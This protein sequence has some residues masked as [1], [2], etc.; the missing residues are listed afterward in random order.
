[1]VLPPS[2]VNDLCE[3]SYDARAYLRGQTFAAPE[4]T[5]INC[6]QLGESQFPKAPTIFE[7]GSEKS[8]SARPQIIPVSSDRMVYIQGELPS[9]EQCPLLA[10]LSSPS[11]SQFPDAIYFAQTPG[12]IRTF[13]PVC[14]QQLQVE[15]LSTDRN[16]APSNQKVE[17]DSH[18]LVPSD[19]ERALFL[20]GCSTAALWNFL[21][22]CLIESNH[23]GNVCSWTNLWEMR[24][25]N[26]NL[27]ASQW[28]VYNPDNSKGE[29]PSSEQ[30]PLLAQLSSPSYSQFPDAIYFAQTPGAIR[31]FAPVCQQQ[32][33]VE[34]LSTD[35]NIAPSNQK[36]END[37][38]LLVPS[39]NERA[40]FLKGCSTAALWNFL[41]DCLIESNH[42]GNVCSWTN[43]WE[44]RIT[45][46]NLFASQWN[47][48]NP[49]NSKKE[50]RYLSVSRALKRF[51]KMKWCGLVLL[52]SSPCRRNTFRFLPEHNSPM[53][54]LPKECPSASA[55][56]DQPR[57]STLL[58]NNYYMLIEIGGKKR[59]RGKKICEERTLEE[60]MGIFRSKKQRME[61]VHSIATS[62]ISC[63]NADSPTTVSSDDHKT[64][65]ATGIK[66]ATETNVNHSIRCQTLTL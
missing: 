5:L 56:S 21:I 53:L 3:S 52:K 24:I 20:K 44:M 58:A 19:N 10:Q 49:D 63:C 9:S 13:A 61:Y 31:T 64:G 36:V 66:N 23:Y 50:V 46:T 47:V 6:C 18:L 1:M 62:Q 54:P 38:H 42:Y 28:N 8:V 32:L 29:L 51:E 39:D 57:R 26:T 40:L 45:N 11:Y 35:R 34:E 55:I 33:Q 30:C 22:D 43:L 7:S 60:K 25:T 59:V 37:S 15:E 48:Y 27:F 16:I 17:N 41:I 14:Q 65:S 2:S 12:A 4:G